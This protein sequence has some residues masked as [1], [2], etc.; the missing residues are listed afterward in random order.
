MTETFDYALLVRPMRSITDDHWDEI[1]TR[2]IEAWSNAVSLLKTWEYASDQYV[3]T[4]E[5]DWQ[6]VLNRLRQLYQW[7]LNFEAAVRQRAEVDLR[8]PRRPV[9]VNL[10]AAVVRC[11]QEPAP[12]H[13]AR[14]HVEN[15]VYDV[16]LMMNMASAGCCNFYT[17]SLRARSESGFSRHL[18]GHLELSEY[19]FDL[20]TLDGHAGKWPAP[21]FLPLEQ[22]IRWYRTVRVGATQVPNNRMEKVLFAL[23]HLARTEVSVN[24]V[25]WLFYALETF[26]DTRQ[27]ENVRALMNRI[28][29]LLAPT[30]KQKAVLKKKLRALYDV[31]SSFVHGGREVIHPLHNEAIDPR[32]EKPYLELIR[33]TEFGFSVLLASIQE[34]VLRGWSEVLFSEAMSGAPY[35]KVTNQRT[36]DPRS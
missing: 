21:R 26:F 6:P 36:D 5:A 12:E 30:D 3:I 32:I 29:L 13:V 18:H 7:H 25:V 11:A 14:Y 28:A 4:I 1:E 23:L 2:H 16:F 9:R 15:F 19:N 20:A 24:T 31:R 27:G 22:V 35:A 8:L 17:A 10:R 34:T 33:T